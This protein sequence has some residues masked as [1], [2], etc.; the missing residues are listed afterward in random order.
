MR[1]SRP[2]PEELLARLG[3]QEAVDL[4]LLGLALTHSSSKAASDRQAD[5]ERLEYLGDAVL[6]LSISHWLYDQEPPLPEGAMSKMRAYVVSDANLARVAKSLDLGRYVH[7]GSS[8]RT[9]GGHEKQSTLANTFEAVLGALFLSLGFDKTAD[10]ARRLLEPTLR[11]ARAGRAEEENYKATL[12]EFTQ[13]Q[14]HQLPIYEV[15]AE[16]GPAHARQFTCR[17]LLAAQVLGQGAG[18]TKKMAEQ[19]AAQQALATLR[20]AAAVAEEAP[21]V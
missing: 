10:V 6:K 12:Q 18:S 7:L 16:Q 14:F 5:N 13:A 17:V 11:E 2:A 19:M 21:H 4:P 9:S 1:M 8:E 3:V 15:V 20:Q